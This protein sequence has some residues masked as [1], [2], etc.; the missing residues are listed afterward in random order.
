MLKKILAV[1]VLATMLGGSIFI[2]PSCYTSDI[3]S[4]PANGNKPEHYICPSLGIAISE[5]VGSF[6]RVYEH[7]ITA[8]STLLI[9]V[10]T[11][12][13]AVAGGLQ[14]CAIMASIK[15]AIDESHYAHRAK[16]A[17]KRI[18]SPRFAVGNG[19]VVTIDVVN[20]GTRDA[21]IVRYG[22][23]IFIRP[24]S[25]YEYRSLDASFI[26]P[27]STTVLKPGEQYRLDAMGTNILTADNVVKIKNGDT[28]IIF[29]SNIQY[30]DAAGLQVASFIRIY[31][32]SLGCFP[33]P[34]QSPKA[35]NGNTRINASAR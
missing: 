7:E 34:R 25:P 21:T 29:I 28:D 2:I 26:P 22:A 33:V 5:K 6:S 19:A 14:Y 3:A 20:S 11:V 1:L 31:D 23:D 17:I 13:L 15:I 8:L 4:N 32:H 35:K 27:P 9:A 24:K 18:H 10:F 12:V 30:T 16:L